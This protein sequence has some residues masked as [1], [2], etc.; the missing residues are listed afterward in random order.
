MLILYPLVILRKDQIDLELK[1]MFP[2]LSHIYVISAEAGLNSTGLNL[3][4][5]SLC[6]ALQA[7]TKNVM[8]KIESIDFS[9]QPTKFTPGKFVRGYD[10]L[11]ILDFYVHLQLTII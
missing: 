1:G 8:F 9:E 3:L 2:L 11:F 10:I 4:V 6:L 7:I 5:T